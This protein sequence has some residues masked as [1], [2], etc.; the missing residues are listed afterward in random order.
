MSSAIESDPG[1]AH[2]RKRLSAAIQPFRHA[3]HQR[4]Q[5]LRDSLAMC[6]V[7]TLSG[8]E[9]EQVRSVSLLRGECQATH[10]YPLQWIWQY[11][12]AGLIQHLEQLIVYASREP[13]CK[14]LSE[15]GL[16]GFAAENGLAM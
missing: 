7:G 1:F 10:K 14:T 8:P 11:L 3:F 16:S 6:E 15:R 12:G 9:C 4:V 2:R 13:A 5:K